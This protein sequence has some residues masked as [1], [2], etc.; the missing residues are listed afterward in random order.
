MDREAPHRVLNVLD[1]AAGR[2]VDTFL[3][4][5]FPSWSRSTFARW[6]KEGVVQSDSRT[7]KPSSVLRLGEVLRIWAPGIAPTEGPPPPPRRGNMN[8]LR[9]GTPRHRTAARGTAASA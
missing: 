9:E 3:S 5:R 8:A 1:R 4:M 6:I 7:L 2:R